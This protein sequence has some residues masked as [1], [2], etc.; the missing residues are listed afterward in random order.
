MAH[1]AMKYAT[2]ELLQVVWSYGEIRIAHLEITHQVGEHARLRLV[3]RV[4]EETE[5]QIMTKSGLDHDI[6]LYDLSVEGTSK[7]LF[8]GRIEQISITV[9]HEQHQIVVEAVSHTYDMDTTK[10]KRSFQ[11][12]KQQYTEI[13]DEV[14]ASYAESDY[15][16]FT[17]NGRQTGKFIMQ[18]EETDWSFLKRLASHGGASLIADVSSH[19]PR[20]WIGIPEGRKQITLEDS[21]PFE[22]TR[23]IQAYS[24]TAS[25]DHIQ[26]TQDK[27]TTYTFEWMSVLDIGDEVIKDGVVY[28][29]A[30]RQAE[31]SQGRLVWI[32]E[33]GPREGYKRGKIHNNAIIGA[34]IDGKI[35]GVSRQQVKVHLD[36][37]SGQNPEAAQWFPYAAEGNQV[38][39]MMPEKGSKIKLYFPSKEEDDAFVIQ[40]VRQEPG[41]NYAAKQQQKMADPGVKTFGNPQGKEFT[42]GD[43]ELNIT[44]RE[45]QLYIGMNSYTGVNLVGSRQVRI[46]AAGGL[47]ISGNQVEVAASNSLSLERIADTLEADG[48]SAS[49]TGTEITGTLELEKD[50]NSKSELIE[51]TATGEREAYEPILSEFE[52]DVQKYGRQVVKTRKYQESADARLEGEVEA[53]KDTAKGLWGFVVDVGDMGLTTVHQLTSFLRL[54]SWDEADQDIQNLYSSISGKE[55]APLKE[56]NETLKGV[57]SGIGYVV[58]TF[59]GEKSPEEI[60]GDIKQGLIS[61]KVGIVDPVVTSF[62]GN[63]LSY[64]TS[65]EEENYEVGYSSGQTKVMALEVLETAVTSGG[66]LSSKAARQLKPDGTDLKRVITDPKNLIKGMLNPEGKQGA[67]GKIGAAS[68]G[69]FKT[70]GSA[71]SQIMDS[72]GETADRMNRSRIENAPFRVLVSQTIEGINI[73]HIV[74]NENYRFFSKNGDGPDGKKSKVEGTGDSNSIGKIVKDGNKTKYTNPAGNELSWTDQHPKSINNDID[75]KLNSTDPGKATEAKVASF[76]RENKEVTGFGQQI[77][78]ADN[79]LAGDLDVVTKNEIIEVKKSIKAVTDVE[80]FDK[81]TNPNNGNYFNP[82][83]KKVIL[84]IDKQLTNLHP[85]DLKKLQEIKSKGVTI[86]NSLDELKEALK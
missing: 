32:Y 17:F 50:I 53:Y 84:Y 43:K 18:Y 15:I 62:K 47:E 27:T 77:R 16:D 10:R 37:D 66:S 19:K 5:A 33:C 35:I 20:F 40:S 76:V 41:G 44:G 81:Y 14:I 74:K 70:R 34:A 38:W 78:K 45:A 75:A 79:S 30:K 9:M 46:L 31:M 26:K 49:G 51:F 2:N 52:Q 48:E 60:G 22:V 59:Q 65:T 29:I 36:M 13:F 25:S 8:L 56:R 4:P 67:L 23:R 1:Q 73:P 82:D 63:S 61:A 54:Q 57:L 86:V 64:Y 6:E 11:H 3:G 85:N 39:Y 71:L 83:Q 28:V 21:H 42:L 12:V 69:R 80:Q 68:D 72:L 7:G 58:D 55:V 24:Y